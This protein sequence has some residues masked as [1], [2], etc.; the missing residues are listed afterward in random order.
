MLGV[1]FRRFPINTHSPTS[2]DESKLA[3]SS[4]FGCRLIRS[5]SHTRGESH[6][7][8]CRGN[9]VLGQCHK[10]TNRV[11]ARLDGLPHQSSDSSPW[12]R[13]TGQLTRMENPSSSARGKDRSA[14]QLIRER[15]CPGM[16]FGTMR[17]EKRRW[18][19]HSPA[20]GDLA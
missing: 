1:G 3:G 15:F 17:L 11:I 9:E 7:S 6:R 16:P 8:R 14:Y 13:K 10:S 2:A 18:S 12:P 4:Q 19:P 20:G 5:V